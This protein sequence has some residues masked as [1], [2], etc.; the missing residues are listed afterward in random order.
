MQVTR[1]TQILSVIGTG[2]LAFVVG[3]GLT[4]DNETKVSNNPGTM[5]PETTTT[6]EDK[7]AALAAVCIEG[8]AKVS[9]GLETIQAGSALLPYASD[10]QVEEFLAAAKDFVQT[11]IGIVNQCSSLDPVAAGPARRALQ[12]LEN[13]IESAELMY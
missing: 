10:A 5:V 3:A 2:I 13:V 11:S 4:S 9:E 8:M 12:D 6:T 1:K 7:T